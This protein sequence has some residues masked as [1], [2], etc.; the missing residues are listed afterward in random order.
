MY[1]WHKKCYSILIKFQSSDSEE[2]GDGEAVWVE[3]S[4]SVDAPKLPGQQPTPQA[5]APH[6]QPQESST[7]GGVK[8]DGWME[9]QRPSFMHDTGLELEAAADVVFPNFMDW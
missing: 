7:R 9:V 8:R 3:R 5:P 1:R 4:S 6:P 2:E